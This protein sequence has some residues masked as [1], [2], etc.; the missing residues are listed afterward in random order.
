MQVINTNKTKEN[1]MLPPGGC[2]NRVN[3]QDHFGNPLPS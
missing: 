2:V 3:R 1:K